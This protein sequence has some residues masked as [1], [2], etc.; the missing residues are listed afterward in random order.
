MTSNNSNTAAETRIHIA[1]AGDLPAAIEAISTWPAVA[2]YWA[3]RGFAGESQLVHCL[4]DDATAII[5]RLAPQ[6]ERV[7]NNP[8]LWVE[9]SAPQLIAHDEAIVANWLALLTSWE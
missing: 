1:D 8:I 9:R 7:G 3:P 5:R 4:P 6:H 2:V